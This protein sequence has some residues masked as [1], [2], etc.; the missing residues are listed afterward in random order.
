MFLIPTILVFYFQMNNCVNIKGVKN[1]KLPPEI[2][3]QD[4]KHIYLAYIPPVV[5]L[6]KW[7]P[8]KATEIN[9]LKFHNFKG[10]G[11]S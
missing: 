9:W 1:A 8:L 6:T 7:I 3:C 5:D 10:R 11:R 4:E 2:V